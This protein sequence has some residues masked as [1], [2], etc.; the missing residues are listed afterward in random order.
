MSTIKS[1]AS[2][3]AGLK[4]SAAEKKRNIVRVQLK[5]FDGTLKCRKWN[6]TAKRW[7]KW[8]PLA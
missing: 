4:F 1:K 3:M 5:N 7:G 6:Y 2:S 8:A